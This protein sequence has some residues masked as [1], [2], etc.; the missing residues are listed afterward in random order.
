MIFYPCS[1]KY[2]VNVF[3]TFSEKN[4][5]LGK[6]EAHLAKWNR[7]MVKPCLMHS[8]TPR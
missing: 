3:P 8:F 4:E 7:R 6:G 1:F 2:V 5:N